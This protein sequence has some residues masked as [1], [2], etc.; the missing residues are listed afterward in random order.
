MA[1]H[2]SFVQLL[3][4]WFNCSEWFPRWKSKQFVAVNQNDSYVTSKDGCNCI[5]L[6]LRDRWQRVV[7]FAVVPCMVDRGHFNLSP[8]CKWLVPIIPFDVL[9]TI[10][11]NTLPLVLLTSL[12]PSSLPKPIPISIFF[13]PV[14]MRGNKCV[15]KYNLADLYQRKLSYQ[16][17]LYVNS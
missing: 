5:G 9:S 2:S 7:L 4:N 8:S 13:I 11:I 3:V 12:F 15:G 1:F 17:I 10:L 6:A 14:D 16:I